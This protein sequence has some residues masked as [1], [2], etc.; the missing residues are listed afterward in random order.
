MSSNV[1]VGRYELLQQIGQGA[2]GQIWEAFDRNLQ[3]AVAVKLMSSAQLESKTARG[4]FEREARAIATLHSPNVVQVFDAGIQDGLPFIVMERLAGENLESR[5]ER[6]GRLPLP[7]LV[8]IVQQTAKAL[9]AAQARSLVHRDLKPANVFL[10]RTDANDETVK[11]LDFGVVSMLGDAEQPPPAPGLTMQGSLVG[12]PLYMS[13]E[14]IRCD[15]VDHRSDLWSLAVLVY[16]ALTGEQPF[17]GE[18]L[19]HLIVRI[20][21]DPFPPPSTILPGLSA[22]VDAFFEKALAK[23]PSKRFPSAAEFSSAFAALANPN[24]EGGAAKILVVDDEPDVEVLMLKRFRKQVQDATYDF[25]FARDGEGA[26]AVLRE[27]PDVDMVLTDINMPRMDGLTFL[28]HLGRVNPIARAIVVSAYSEMSNI[29]TA[30]NRGA[31][32]FLVKPIDFKDLAATIEKTRKHVEELRRSARSSEENSLLRMFMSPRRLSQAKPGA[33]ATLAE[34]FSG[35]VVVIGIH[36]MDG[37]LDGSR[38]EQSIRA[39]NANFEVIIPAI[40]RRRGVIEKFVGDAVMA[41]FRDENHL[42]RA[43][44]ACLDIRAQLL[45]LA[46]QAGSA[47]P[48][49]IGV[50]M[51]IATGEM[52]A[53]EI[54]SRAFERVDDALLGEV[55]KAAVVLQSV[56]RKNQVLVTGAA[57]EATRGDFD[58]VPVH[59][60]ASPEGSVVFELA[61]RA[62]PDP[63]QRLDAAEAATIDNLS[64]DDGWDLDVRA[65]ISGVREQGHDS[66]DRSEGALPLHPTRGSAP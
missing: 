60:V 9:L 18:W 24:A 65:S 44:D 33:A 50:A 61:R 64:G 34:A 7:A 31:F 23:D 15:A 30:M 58:Q 17:Q 20:C 54:G 45:K 26:L 38:P 52:I 14:Q 41:V 8:P 51:G 47:S 32:D 2:M 3:R 29:R 43:L 62:M 35:T 4:R 19:G 55:P 40:A 11:I 49:A 13:P 28:S 21:T 10:A 16:R 1:M 42:H 39:L 48:F 53:G 57:F 12:T 25:I 5:L 6:V 46:G 63:F 37:A 66:P 27:H 22:A 36:G 59:G 56:A